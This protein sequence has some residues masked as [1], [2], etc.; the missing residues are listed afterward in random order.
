MM[1]VESDHSEGA[2]VIE[3]GQAAQDRASPNVRVR[4]VQIGTAEKLFWVIAAIGLPLT[5]WIDLLWHYQRLALEVAAREPL[6]A[7]LALLGGLGLLTWLANASPR[8]TS[9]RAWAAGAWFVGV[10]AVAALGVIGIGALM[11]EPKGNAVV[12]FD[13]LI[14]PGQLL[15][16]LVVSPLLMLAALWFASR[17]FVVRIPD[18]V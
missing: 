16:S 8:G 12:L 17:T 1:G 18:A 6:A 11:P 14:V 7:C 9:V 15:L 13:W 3:G 10:I 5:I 4:R 2:G